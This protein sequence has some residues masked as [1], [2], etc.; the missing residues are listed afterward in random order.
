VILGAQVS[1]RAKIRKVIFIDKIRNVD[2]HSIRSL[3]LPINEKVSSQ[4]YLKIYVHENATSKINKGRFEDCNV[5]FG[6]PS[7]QSRKKI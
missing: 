7:S 6:N 2:G 1:G 5:L 4:D 3:F